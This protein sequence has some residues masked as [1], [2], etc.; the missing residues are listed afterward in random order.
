MDRRGISRRCTRRTALADRRRAVACEQA[1]PGCR[2]GSTAARRL[3][4][5]SALARPHR[6]VGARRAGSDRIAAAHPWRDRE[7]RGRPRYAARSRKGVD[8]PRAVD[9]VIDQ[10]GGRRFG[11]ATTAAAVVARRCHRAGGAGRMARAAQGW[12]RL[13]SRRR[14]RRC[15]RRARRVVPARRALDGKPGAAGARNGAAIRRQGRERE[16]SRGPGS[17]PLCLHREGA[18]TVAAGARA[19]FHR[20]R[21]GFLSRPR[22]V[23]P[24]SAQRLVRAVSTMPSRPPTGCAPAIGWSSTSGAAS[25]TTLRSEAFAGTAT[26]PC[27]SSSSCSITAARCSWSDDRRVAPFRR[28]G[29]GLGVR[30]RH[31]RRN[32]ARRARQSA[33]CFDVDDR[34]RILR[35]R[36][37]AYRLDACGVAFGH[38]VFTAQRSGCPF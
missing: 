24:V 11:R 2:S 8:G 26:S 37:H 21:R 13:A 27:L 16:A 4:R 28:L 30:H 19:R 32:L 7:T 29:T 5:R 36:F 3:A 31:R 35:R 9:R 20:R 1:R 15:R 38:P 17:R 12:T 18:R 10:H 22:R 6:R 23:S 14:V 34:L 33:G 25:R